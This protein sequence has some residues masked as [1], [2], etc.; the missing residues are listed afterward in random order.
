V[1]TTEIEHFPVWDGDRHAF[2][3]SFFC[4]KMSPKMGS[5]MTSSRLLLASQ[6][7][8]NRVTKVDHIDCVTPWLT[9]G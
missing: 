5:K 6:F 9:T 3:T 2:K 1:R 7:A 4:P 8:A